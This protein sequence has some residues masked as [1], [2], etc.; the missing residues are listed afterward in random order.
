MDMGNMGVDAVNRTEQSN[1]G[2]SDVNTNSNT[3]INGTDFGDL[4]KTAQDLGSGD[5]KKVGEAINDLVAK[6][7]KAVGAEPKEE[8]GEGEAPPAESGGKTG[9]ASGGGGEPEGAGAGGV[10]DL[11]K[12]LAEALGLGPEQTDK[13]M[14]AVNEAK[15][16]ES[17]KQSGMQAPADATP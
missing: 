5:P 6:I 11:I 9:G 16:A 4:G 12:Q 14:Q 2:G 7:L 1:S 3:Q 8:A 15:E 10:E 17:G 13:L